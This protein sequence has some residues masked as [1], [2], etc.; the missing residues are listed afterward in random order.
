MQALSY[1][2][3][4]YQALTPITNYINQQS[5]DWDLLCQTSLSLC[6]GRKS[7]SLPLHFSIPLGLLQPGC[8]PPPAPSR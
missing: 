7:Q 8:L 6:L 5:L 1:Q 3:A 2:K 4:P